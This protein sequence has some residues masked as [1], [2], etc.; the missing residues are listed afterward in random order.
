LGRGPV[1]NHGSVI[2]IAFWFISIVAFDPLVSSRTPFALSDT[3]ILH[4]G[5]SRAS[6]HVASQQGRCGLN[7]VESSR[8]LTRQSSILLFF[9]LFNPVHAMP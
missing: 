3:Q 4:V 6:R 7:M 8:L 1:E 2:R 5:G 9:I